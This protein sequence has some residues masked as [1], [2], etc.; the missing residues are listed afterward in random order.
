MYLFFLMDAKQTK[1]IATEQEG[2]EVAVLG[3]ITL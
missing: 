1:Y 2:L 3:I